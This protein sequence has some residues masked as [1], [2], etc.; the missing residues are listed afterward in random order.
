MTRAALLAQAA[1]HVEQTGDFGRT[2]IG[3]RLVEDEQLGAAQDRLQDLDA[4]ALTSG[5]SPTIAA[6]SR[7]SP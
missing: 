6:G 1:H 3:S 4:L 5:R 2:E 7:S